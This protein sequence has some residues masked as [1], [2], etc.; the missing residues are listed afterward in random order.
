MTPHRT[1]AASLLVTLLLVTFL[2]PGCAKIRQKLWMDVPEDETSLAVD[3]GEDP[4][5]PKRKLTMVWHHHSTGDDLLKGGLRKAID[6]NNI[7]FFDINY[8]EAK[9]GDYVIGDRT[10]PPDFP[11]NFNTPEYY[12]VIAGWELKGDKQHDVIMFKSCFPASDIKDDAML[13]KYKEYYESMLPTFKANPKTLFVGM[14]TPPLTAGKTTA[15]NAARARKWA[16]WVT[17]EYAKELPNVQVFDLFGAMSIREG[18]PNQGTLPPQF[19]VGK[20]D[21]HPAGKAGEAVARQFIPWF[22][23]AVR[24]AG[25][26]K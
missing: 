4:G 17:S 26:D 21:S 11:K 14:S 7:D 15:D 8:K 1:L 10:D 19:A 3:P 25:L 16:K 9:V 23:R 24:A 12:K 22:N 18:A 5:P 2:A 20:W 6:D 13:Q